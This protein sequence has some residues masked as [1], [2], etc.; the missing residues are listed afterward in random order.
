MSHFQFYYNN[1][2]CAD[3][4]DL[5]LRWVYGYSQQNLLGWLLYLNNGNEINENNLSS[6]GQCL[7]NITQLAQ[8]VNR[9][10]KGRDL[11][12]SLIVDS[13]YSLV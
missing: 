6:S 10:P 7:V 11:N 8:P 4:L 13:L 3:T 9:S 12:C 2:V 5:T 1:H